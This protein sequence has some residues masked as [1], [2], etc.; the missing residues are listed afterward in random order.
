M[1]YK[2]FLKQALIGVLSSKIVVASTRDHEQD[3]SLL[4]AKIYDRMLCRDGGKYSR[5]P[6]LR[7][8]SCLA[9]KT[10]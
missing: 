2:V 6:L 10:A 3:H 7:G 5:A 4:V 9:Q 8:G 1:A